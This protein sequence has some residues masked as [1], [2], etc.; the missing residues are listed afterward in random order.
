MRS[1]K[2]TAAAA[3][4]AMLCSCGAQTTQTDEKEKIQVYTSFYAMYDFTCRIA[5]DSADVYNMCPP[6]SEPHDFEPTASDMAKLTDADV[7]IYNGM[8]MEHWTDSIT[9]TLN[10]S[11]VIITEASEGVPSLTENYDPHVWL[12]PENA[13]KEYENIA[14]AL[15]LA[16]P[17]NRGYYTARLDEVLADLDKL[18]NDYKSA[19][20]GFRS[21]NI[22]TSHEAYMNLCDAYGLIQLAVNGVDN[23]EDPTP[24]RMAE[25]E[26]FI[27]AN[28]IKYVFT[29]PLSTSKIIQTIAD[30]T[31]CEILTLDPFEGSTENKDYFTVMYENLDAL[32]TALS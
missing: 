1:I 12:D 15:I 11:D 5:G 22:I 32:K 30:D 20:S 29:E 10:G 19:I 18:D 6:G 24:T 3:A 21:H 7:F 8:G 13:A 25:I 2:L 23:S 9:E 28:D 4:I 27:K 26:D 14:N 16:D 17:D 31:G